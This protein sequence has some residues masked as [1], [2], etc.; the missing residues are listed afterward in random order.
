MNNIS[1]T[2]ITSINQSGSDGSNPDTPQLPVSK[3]SNTS[4]SITDIVV[5]HPTLVKVG[6]LALGAAQAKLLYNSISNG[7]V[8]NSMKL[9]GSSMVT[10]LAYKGVDAVVERDS[11]LKERDIEVRLNEIKQD[12]MMNDRFKQ[13]FGHK[14]SNPTDYIEKLTDN[15]ASDILYGGSSNLERVALAINNTKSKFGLDEGTCMLLRKDILYLSLGLTSSEEKQKMFNVNG[16]SAWTL[17]LYHSLSINEEECD[18]VTNAA[19]E[20]M[21][22]PNHP[23]PS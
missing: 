16:S 14:T 7:E 13:V 12:T 20:V 10:Y 2:N 22:V 3:V 9:L 18:A 11:L 5:E 6:L 19:L 4:K 8:I 21:E 1:S 23:L 17:S 15:Q